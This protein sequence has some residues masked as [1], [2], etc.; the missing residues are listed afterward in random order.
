MILPTFA[1]LDAIAIEP[2]VPG[3]VYARYL[4]HAS[5]REDYDA[6][7]DRCRCLDEDAALFCLAPVHRRPW[8]AP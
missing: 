6:D 2:S 4:E 3:D 1:Q 8:W 7:D 5:F